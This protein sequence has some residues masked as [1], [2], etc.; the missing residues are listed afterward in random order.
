MS[1]FRTTL[2]NCQQCGRR[3]MV[4]PSDAERGSIQCSHIGCGAVN[5]LATGSYFDETIVRGLPG[6]GQLTYL[7]DQASTYPLQ[8][9]RNVIGTSDLATIRVDRFMHNGKC[10]ISR[11][12]CTLT[13][14]FDKWA[15][16]LRYQL[17]DGFADPETREKQF[18]LNGTSLNHIALQKTEVIDVADGGIITL[19]GADRFQLTHYLIEPVMLSTYKVDLAFNPDHTQ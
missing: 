7:N 11:R 1:G 8:F 17:E 14:T 5:T 9:G 3:I 10:F 13:I 19:G 4:R 16:T 2:I 15:G 6:F 18:S 12:H